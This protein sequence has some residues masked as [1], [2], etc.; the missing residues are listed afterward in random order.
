MTAWNLDMTAAPRDRL[1]HVVGRYPD[2]RAGV[3]TYAAWQDETK[4]GPAGFYVYSRNAP[5]LLIVWAWAERDN[6]PNEPI[7]TETG[8]ITPQSCQMA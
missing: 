8:Q 6:W 7:S 5:E 4:W 1:L 2:A 3:P